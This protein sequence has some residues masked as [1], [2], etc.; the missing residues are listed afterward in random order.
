MLR[1]LLKI[2]RQQFE[3]HF[4]ISG[5]KCRRIGYEKQEER[6]IRHIASLFNTNFDKFRAIKRVL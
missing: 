6:S 4:N 1:V 3:H 2:S 5:F